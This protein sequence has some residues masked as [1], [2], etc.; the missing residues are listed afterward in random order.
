MYAVLLR[1]PAEMLGS[2]SV[3]V[4]SYMPAR[5]RTRN[6]KCVSVRGERRQSHIRLSVISGLKLVMWGASEREAG[7]VLCLFSKLLYNYIA[8]LYGVIK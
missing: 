6:G 4:L 1:R 3:S 8:A 2:L 7:L 5:Q